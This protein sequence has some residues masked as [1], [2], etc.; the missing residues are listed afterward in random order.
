MLFNNSKKILTATRRTPKRF[1][2]G[3][4]NKI[5]ISIKSNFSIPISLRIIDEVPYQFQV[6][7]FEINEHFKTKTE[8]TIQY[9]LHPVKRGEYEYG[10]LNVYATTVLGLVSRRFRFENNISVPVYPSYLQMRKYELLA[11][12]H[13]LTDAGIKKI[14][15]ISNNREFEEIRDYIKGDEFRTINWKATARMNKLMVNQF[16]DEKSQQV[17]SIIDMGRTMK[18]PFE[19][20]SLLDYAINSSLVISNIAIIKKDKAGLITFSKNIHSVL[21]ATR[22]NTQMAQILQVL[23]KQKTDFLEANYELLYSTIRKKITKRSLLL[24]Y[25]NFEGITSLQ[26]Q[27]NYFKRLSKSHLIVVIFFENTEIKEVLNKKPVSTEEIYIKTIAEKFIYEKRQIV[28]EL[29]KYGIHSILTEPKKLTVN[30]IN[31]YLELKAIGLI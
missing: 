17:Y 5:F 31:K 15:K 28:K 2:N 26:R 25:T 20:M 9:I 10:L 22:K 16:Q 30:T 11:I 3:D 8:K 21:P 19:K 12:S 6:R 29:K 13:K 7:D 27:L 18:K 1:S 4:D 24:I 14:R 23:Y